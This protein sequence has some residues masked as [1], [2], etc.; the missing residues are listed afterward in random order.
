MR[1]RLKP[2]E[3]VALRS[4]ISRGAQFTPVGLLSWQKKF[5][6][7]LWRREIVT[8]WFRQAPGLGMQGPF[9]GLS[10][11]GSYVASSLVPAPRGNSEAEKERP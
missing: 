7:D 3:V 10:I 11:H 6:L 1:A 8:I 5:V 2:A 9:Y 4:L